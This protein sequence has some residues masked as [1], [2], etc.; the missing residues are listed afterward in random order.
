M[1]LAASRVSDKICTERAIGIFE[2]K[3]DLITYTLAIP[4]RCR[5][6]RSRGAGLNPSSIV[7]NSGLLFLDAKISLNFQ[8]VGF[9]SSINGAAVASDRESA[10]ITCSSQ[11][12]RL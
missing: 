8:T 7:Q 10:G 6:T 2:D 5:P 3:I 4:Q 9:C 11:P 1:P 12:R